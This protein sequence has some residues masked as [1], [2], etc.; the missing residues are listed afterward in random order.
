MFCPGCGNTVTSGGR[1]CFHCGVELPVT[2]ATSGSCRDEATAESRTA[3]AGGDDPLAGRIIEGKYRLEERIGVGGMGAVYRATR[4][5]IGDTVAVKLMHA[6]FVRD[7]EAERFRR[8]A[9][10]AA[11]LKH[12]NAVGVYDFGLTQDGTLYLVMELVEGESLR[13]LI[14]RQGVLEPA[15]ACEIIRQVCAALDE[16]H[17]RHIVHRDIKPD[18]VIVDTTGK[19][20]RVKV[21]DFGVAKLRDV[22]TTTLTQT[23]SVVGTPHYMSP[24]Q[25]LG[26]DLDQRSDIYSAGIVLYE[27]LCGAV[28]FNAPISTAVI[29]QHVN[30]P[31]PPLRGKNP[32]VTPALERAI[33]HALEKRREDRPQSAGA[34]AGEVGE[35]LL[36]HAWTEEVTWDAAGAGTFGSEELTLDAGVYGA[37][38]NAGG[39][40]RPPVS[41]AQ[42]AA[43]EVLRPPASVSGSANPV[44]GLNHFP[45]AGGASMRSMRTAF[46]IGTTA[47]LVLLG[48]GGTAVWLTRGG[49]VD[50]A[51]DAKGSNARQGTQPVPER[52]SKTSGAKEAAAE[53][54]GADPARGG[55]G[56]PQ[57]PP[58]MS[59]VPGGIFTMG[60]NAGDEYERPAHKVT[61][62]PFFIDK[63]EVTCEEYARF[64]AETNHPRLPIGW[65]GRSCPDGSGRMPVR[66]VSWDDASAY[67]RW[68][69]KRLPTE[70]EWELAARGTDARRYPWGDD[71][72]PGLANADGRSGAAE[73]G[74]YGGASP[75]GAFDM[76]GNVWEWTASQPA[77][78]PGGPV[79]TLK[80]GDFRVIRGGAWSTPKSQATTTYRGYLERGSGDID[81]T[82]FRCAKD[83]PK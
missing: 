37:Q 69:G 39:A 13:Q 8:E 52:R 12:P 30:Q 5:L 60:S 72:R 28:P 56:Q 46:V 77:T 42:F 45:R 21:L 57:P 31:P 53:G 47:L 75:S 32:A 51:S 76:V 80:A 26:E 4:L 11:R 25:C 27:M 23:G 55:R 82:G 22:P 81:K 34:F 63:Y 54:G 10:A 17:R 9:Q 62:S 7:A 59:Y 18:N 83:V 24:E 70:E 67:A 16:A 49:E 66:G 40:P 15:I 73:V 14:K 38:P 6:D 43:T 64:L 68:A 1:F 20:P 2:Q 61:L 71:W 50:G 3:R 41:G 78:Y 58:G 65:R 19:S 48:I 79:L 33:L 35:A 29:V 36:G 74:Q 44:A